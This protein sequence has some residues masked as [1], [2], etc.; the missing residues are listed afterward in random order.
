M[1]VRMEIDPINAAVTR[2]AVNALA[3]VREYY[4]VQ[5]ARRMAKAEYLRLLGASIRQFENE[6]TKNVQMYNEF[7]AHAAAR[8]FR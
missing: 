2:S 5:A 1:I 7:R 3:Q 6:Q 4:E 8:A